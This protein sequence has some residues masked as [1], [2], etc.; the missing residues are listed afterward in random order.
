[1]SLLDLELINIKRR[2]YSVSNDRFYI[3]L[4]RDLFYHQI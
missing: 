4:Y 3:N 2:Y 1:M